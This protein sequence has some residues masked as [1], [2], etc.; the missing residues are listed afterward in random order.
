M[1]QATGLE[2]VIHP[3][4]FL[5][6]CNTTDSGATPQATSAQG[7]VL[8]SR[9]RPYCQA[10]RAGRGCSGGG[11]DPWGLQVASKPLEA[12]S[13]SRRARAGTAAAPRRQ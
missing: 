9:D 2:D 13:P 10:R 4:T 6:F 1:P 11:G 3:G 5:V 7:A 12:A 8:P